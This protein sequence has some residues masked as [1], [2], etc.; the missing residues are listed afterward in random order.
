MW[1][2]LLS[3]AASLNHELSSGSELFN[4][5]QTVVWSI[6]LHSLLFKK[7]LRERGVHIEPCS[8]HEWLHG[9]DPCREHRTKFFKG[10][11]SFDRHDILSCMRTSVLCSGSISC[12]RL[13]ISIYS[14]PEN[15]NIWLILC[16]SYMKRPLNC[17]Q[18]I[19]T[20]RTCCC[21][22]L[23]PPTDQS[24]GESQCHFGTAW[25]TAAYLKL[26][27]VSLCQ[28]SSNMGNQTPSLVIEVVHF[29]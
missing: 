9:R 2:R 8:A 3:S 18:S 29:E 17:L 27:P 11:S 26:H 23:Y 21:C 10:H 19:G 6:L 12:A 24:V 15:A 16:F 25:S 14:T 20:T 1:F 13:L 22:F 4:W 5:T 28:L 7:P